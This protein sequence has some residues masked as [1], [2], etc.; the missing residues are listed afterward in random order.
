VLNDPAAG[1][2][3]HAGIS[4][5]LE[6]LNTLAA[7]PIPDVSKLSILPSCYLAAGPSYIL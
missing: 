4:A 2:P 7:K 5:V 6:Q 1:D 3:T